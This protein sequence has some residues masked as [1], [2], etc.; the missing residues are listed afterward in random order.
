MSAQSMRVAVTA[1]AVLASVSLQAQAPDIAAYRDAVNTYVK[2]GQ[3]AKAVESL[4]GWDRARLDAVVNEI[5]ASGDA[6]LL[7]SAALLHLEIGIAIAGISTPASAAYFDL[8][9]QLIAAL[10]PVKP[11]ARRQLSVERA[12]EIARIRST[13]L[14]VAGS[15]LLSVHD[16]PRARTTLRKAREVAPQ[17]AALMTILGSIDETESGPFNPDEVDGVAAK[18]RIDRERTRLLLSAQRWYKDAL[19]IE[20]GQPLATIRLGRTQFLL[21]DFQ[22]ASQ[23]LERGRVIAKEPAHRYL[24]GMFLGALQQHH[25]DLPGARASYTA[26]LAAAPLS[27]NAIVA[28][29]YVELLIDL[30]GLF[31]LRQRVRR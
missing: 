15:A 17:S 29:A 28:L 21:G 19:E 10:V 23:L 12:A 26:A 5:I 1:A 8:G 22:Q 2:T 11:D 27:Q 9:E 25:K 3:P 13:W 16:T 7:E 4:S 24:A 14:G 30:D 31:W 18:S 20:P 6:A